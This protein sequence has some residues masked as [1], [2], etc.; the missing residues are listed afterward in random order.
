M[1]KNHDKVEID[2]LRIGC[3]FCEEGEVH[4]KCI[5]AGKILGRKTDGKYACNKCEYT[6][7]RKGL[8]RIHNEYKHLKIKRYKCSNCLH[9]TYD[10]K[11]YKFIFGSIMM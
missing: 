11:V 3:K 10:K 6:V 7:D 1:K 5:V 8:L 4:E 2:L 9:E